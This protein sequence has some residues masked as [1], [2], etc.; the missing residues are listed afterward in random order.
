MHSDGF[1]NRLQTYGIKRL[2]KSYDFILSILFITV[3]IVID[4]P[5]VSSFDR[6]EFVASATSIASRLI[7]VILAGV[8]I[9]VSFSDRKFLK[10]LKEEKVYRNLVFT[11]EYTVILA[12]AVSTLG[13]FLQS[14]QIPER[15]FYVFMWSFLYLTLSVVRL[16][17]RIVEFGDKKAT[18]A[19]V[20]DLEIEGD[21]NERE[22]GDQEE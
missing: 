11:F 4:V 3:I 13:A 17:S 9:V 15:L 20:D 16:I 2:V 22:E 18:H 21:F 5:F 8:A 6:A 12:V 1:V 10:L 14:S 7:A 19:L